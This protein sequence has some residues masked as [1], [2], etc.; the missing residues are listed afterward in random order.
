VD[1][2]VDKRS[3]QGIEVGNI[4]KDWEARKIQMNKTT[5]ICNGR[6]NGEVGGMD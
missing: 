4:G 5:E 3:I 1:N 6:R 2:E